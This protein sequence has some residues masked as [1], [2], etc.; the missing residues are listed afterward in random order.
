MLKPTTTTIVWDACKISLNIYHLYFLP[1]CNRCNPGPP[2]IARP[3]KPIYPCSK[4]VQR[5]VKWLVMQSSM[6][7][8]Q[9]QRHVQQQ[10]WNHRIHFLT[11]YQNACTTITPHTTPHH[12]ATP[13]TTSHSIPWSSPGHLPN[14]PTGDW[15][16]ARNACNAGTST[17]CCACEKGT[18]WGAVKLDHHE[19]NDKANAISYIQ[20]SQAGPN[21]EAV[22]CVCR[23]PR[24]TLWENGVTVIHSEYSRYKHY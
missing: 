19:E 15:V 6:N 21:P 13:H 17:Y 12:K 16:I 1:G 18:R 3:A 5:R 14:A 24:A 22:A 7:G 20:H 2:Q 10:Q 11:V 23:F 4:S 9:Q 8:K